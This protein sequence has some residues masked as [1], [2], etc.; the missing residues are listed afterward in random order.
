MK[1]IDIVGDNY[2]G[3]WNKTRTVCIDVVYY[4]IMFILY[5]KRIFVPTLAGICLMFGI[6]MTLDFI[7]SLILYAHLLK[8]LEVRIKI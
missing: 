6:G 4:G 1:I 2:L 7:P 3:K 8:K 5:C